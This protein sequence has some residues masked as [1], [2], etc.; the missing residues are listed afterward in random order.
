LSATGRLTEPWLAP[1]PSGGLREQ[2]SVPRRWAVKLGEALGWRGRL[3]TDPE[4]R[5]CAPP[6]I[7]RPGLLG[8]P[9]SGSDRGAV[10][11]SASPS[12]LDATRSSWPGRSCRAWRTIR[13][14]GAPRSTSRDLPCIMARK[15]GPEPKPFW[16]RGC[17]SHRRSAAA[18]GF[19]AVFGGGHRR[20]RT[21]PSLA[22]SPI[23][24]PETYLML[25]EI[26]GGLGGDALATLNRLSTPSRTTHRF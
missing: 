7:G 3:R 14:T 20:G 16:P 10:R 17:G 23:A 25:A 13:R 26:H 15:S 2:R 4:Y 8:P 11:R 6:A 1:V 9:L 22:S 18:G 19:P 24:T 12:G 21:R 5:P